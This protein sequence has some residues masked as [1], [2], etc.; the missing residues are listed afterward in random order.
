MNT[1]NRRQIVLLDAQDVVT[2]ALVSSD[3]WP[4]LRSGLEKLNEGV[5]LEALERKYVSTYLKSKDYTDS[6]S[7]TIAMPRSGEIQ[8]TIEHIRRKWH[9]DKVWKTLTKH[10]MF[11]DEEE[12]MDNNTYLTIHDDRPLFFQLIDSVSDAWSEMKTLQPLQINSP[13]D[14]SEWQSK[15]R[16][17][18]CNI[19]SLLSTAMVRRPR[20]NNAAIN[21]HSILASAQESAQHPTDTE[22]RNRRSPG[23]R[24]RAQ[25]AAI[26]DLSSPG[27]SAFATAVSNQ[28][29]PASAGWDPRLSLIQ[30][31]ISRETPRTP[32]R[33]GMPRASYEGWMTSPGHQ[34]SEAY[35]SPL[36]DDILR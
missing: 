23:F 9:N 30:V 28:R 8:K 6:I 33:N 32:T 31:P 13:E 14:I 3:T 5:Q 17:V 2:T 21:P 19:D 4:I 15:E 11:P 25:T 36:Q 7:D 1:D 27:L 29:M 34:S 35:R 26:L 10:F 12:V 16:S 24:P 18:S 22:A 20:V